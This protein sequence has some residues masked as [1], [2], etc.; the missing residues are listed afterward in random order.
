MENI[1]ELLE[2]KENILFFNVIPYTIPYTPLRNGWHGSLNDSD[3]YLS[4]RKIGKF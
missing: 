2:Y 3:P 1:E 4:T